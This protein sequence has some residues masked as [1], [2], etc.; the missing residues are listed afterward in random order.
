MRKS[1]LGF[2]LILVLA[3]SAA[4]AKISVESVIP[5]GAAE[6]A[7]LE[8][9]DVFVLLDG[10]KIS[11]MDDLRKVTSVRKPGDTVPLVVQRDGQTVELSLTFGERPGGEVSIGVRLAIETDPADETTH[12]TTECL[13]WIEKTYRIGPMMQ[14]LGLELSEEYKAMRECVAHDTQRM[15]SDNAI[16]YCDN[17]FKMHCSALELL[18]EIAEAQVGRCEE[19]LGESL[20]LN[21]AQHKSWKT[22]AQHEVFD[23]YAKDGASSDEGA[24]RAAFLKKCGANIDAAAT[25]GTLSR[26]QRGFV[27]CC[28]ADSLGPDSSGSADRCAM[29]DE[30]FKRGPCHDQSVCVNR[31][32]G[33]WIRCAASR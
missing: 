11:N 15:S 17:V 31:L 18:A 21:V 3:G 25:D 12:G 26:D 7:G 24:C 4:Q 23:R 1:V 27:E 19:Q 6:A 5:G 22:C 29:I 2:A 30:G 28:S 13:A 32:S 16:K 10:Q 8:A 14:A 9:G 33:D 20:G